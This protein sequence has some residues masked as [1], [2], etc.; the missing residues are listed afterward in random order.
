MYSGIAEATSRLLNVIVEPIYTPL[1]PFASRSVNAD[2]YPPSLPSLNFRTEEK[3]YVG[4]KTTT[5]K[6]GFFYP[7]WNQGLVTVSDYAGAVKVLRVLLG[8]VGGHLAKDLPLVYKLIRI[9]KAHV[10]SV[11]PFVFASHILRAKM[12]RK[13]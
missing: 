1:Q 8:I 2:L 7:D 12:M 9:G 5:S 13:S 11:I 6:Y 4:K 3:V 10:E